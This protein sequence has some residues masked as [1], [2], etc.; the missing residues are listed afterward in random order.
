MSV[1]HVKKCQLKTIN[2]FH[3]K[4]KSVFSLFDYFISVSPLLSTFFLSASTT[5]IVVNVSD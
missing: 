2:F 3:D 5:V 4:H 1:K